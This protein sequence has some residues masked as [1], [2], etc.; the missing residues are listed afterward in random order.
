[1][2]TFW[3][4]SEGLTQLDPSLLVFVFYVISFYLLSQVIKT[5]P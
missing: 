4:K 5:I 2:H 3:V 1:M